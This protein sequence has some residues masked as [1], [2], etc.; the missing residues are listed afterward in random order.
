MYPVSGTEV[1]C[2]ELRGNNTRVEYNPVT[3]LQPGQHHHHHTTTPT[4][5]TSPA[6]S[7]HHIHQQ[8]T[9]P[10]HHH[11]HHNTTTIKQS[12]PSP[13]ATAFYQQ[14]QQHP[15]SSRS[16]TS[17]VDGSSKDLQ[18]QQQQ[19]QP[20]LVLVSQRYASGPVTVKETTS[21]I[22]STS[23]P[24]HRQNHQPAPPPPQRGPVVERQSTYQTLR[25]SMEISKLLP[26][27][28]HNSVDPEDRLKLIITNALN[29]DKQPS[30]TCGSKPSVPTAPS[31]SHGSILVRSSGDRYMT[32]QQQQAFIGNVSRG[33]DFRRSEVERRDLM[34]EKSRGDV[35]LERRPTTELI[36]R[37][38]EDANKREHQQH[39]QLRPVDEAAVGD[40][41]L[42]MSDSILLRESTSASNAL[43]R[44]ADTVS[45]AGA[46]SSSL[47]HHRSAEELRDLMIQEEQ[48]HHQAAVVAQHQHHQA[49][50][51]QQQ[52]H[53]TRA[54]E[55]YPHSLQ[56]Q[57]RGVEDPPLPP[58]ALISHHHI[59][60]QQLQQQQHH[61]AAAPSTSHHQLRQHQPQPGGHLLHGH[62]RDALRM[63][64]DALR[65]SLDDPLHHHH[66]HPP[67]P[68]HHHLH[69][70]D[71]LVV[72]SS[73]ALRQQQVAASMA[74]DDVV[75][76]IVVRDE[77]GVEIMLRGVSG[78]EER[79]LLLD[80]RL[81]GF[82]QPDY[83]QVRTNT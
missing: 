66:S 47:Q 37:P 8:R 59:Q 82:Q 35:M 74:E 32:P 44:P 21:S 26:P 72:T 13:N 75:R 80:P 63:S 30:S 4:T 9:S 15:G 77:R 78:A 6:A 53:M 67:P 25:N 60:Q 65:M 17:F 68:P 40:T 29:E 34:V 3:R 24:P 58:V 43:R 51:Q 31:S 57:Q 27:Q 69:H 50:A 49:A 2:V 42:R 48:Q 55:I 7:Q 83:T 45:A 61:D 71:D 73:S 10:V 1:R 70:R 12:S 11:L 28:Q 38:R 41:L 76:D 52:Q 33:V 64:S 5:T 81:A 20:R 56:H 62:H 36:M 79:R 22:R 54:R 23:P 19:Q 46:S 18:Q 39:L 14:Q 16:A